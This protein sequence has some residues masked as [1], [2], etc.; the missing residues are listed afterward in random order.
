[1]KTL[2]VF[3]GEDY[4]YWKVRMQAYL[5]SIDEKA[6]QVTSNATNENER[7]DLIFIK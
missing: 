4:S 7:L 1:M 6:W 5:E 2:T 3:D